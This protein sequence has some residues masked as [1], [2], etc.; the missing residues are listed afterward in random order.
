MNTKS[1][2][3]R[4]HLLSIGRNGNDGLIQTHFCR[5]RHRVLLCD[6]S[7]C[8]GLTGVL[9]PGLADALFGLDPTVLLI[10][11][12]LFVSCTKFPLLSLLT[13]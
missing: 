10:F 4:S 3:L 5:N 7:T 9:D 2:R 6:R 11:E 13:I 12:L 1:E 8:A